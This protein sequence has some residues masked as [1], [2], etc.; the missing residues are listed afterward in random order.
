MGDYEEGAANA[1][2]SVTEDMGKAIGETFR[3]DEEIR[4]R[5]QS[6][7]S[8]P[9]KYEG[10]PSELSRGYEETYAEAA[11]RVLEILKSD[12]PLSEQLQAIHAAVDALDSR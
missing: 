5:F 1:I 2:H 8:S 11:R 4:Q 7:F 9:E 6:I 12:A 3:P 10:P